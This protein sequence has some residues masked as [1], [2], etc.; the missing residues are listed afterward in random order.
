MLLLGGCFIDGQDGEGACGGTIGLERLMHDAWECRLDWTAPTQAG[1][2][3]WTVWG[4]DTDQRGSLMAKWGVEHAT[5]ALDPARGT[6]IARLPERPFVS[7]AEAK[8]VPESLDSG[9]ARISWHQAELSETPYALRSIFRSTDPVSGGDKLTYVRLADPGHAGVPRLVLPSSSGV[10]LT[11]DG[12]WRRQLHWTSLLGLRLEG[13]YGLPRDLW[14]G[15]VLPSLLP[16]MQLPGELPPQARGRPAAASRA[17]PPTAT[18]Q[19]WEVVSGA[20]RGG[21]IV[22]AGRELGSAKLGER[23]AHGAVVRQEELQGERLRYTRINGSGPASGWVS[24]SLSGKDL[25]RAV[26]SS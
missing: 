8:A 23:L 11:G 5:A 14:F 2:A 1:A 18:G 25:L 17:G 21:L 4:T 6:L 20:D 15:R 3:S 22:R 12:E 13:L 10:L 24:V 19:L 7:V 16:A 9:A 26:P